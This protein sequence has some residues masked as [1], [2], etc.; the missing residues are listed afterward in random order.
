MVESPPSVCPV[1]GGG[2]GCH[3]VALHQVGISLQRSGG[4]CGVN[5]RSGSWVLCSEGGVA[6]MGVVMVL[7]GCEWWSCAVVMEVVWMCW[8]MLV[9][10]SIESKVQLPILYLHLAPYDG[11][12]VTVWKGGANQVHVDVLWYVEAITVVDSWL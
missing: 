11:V 1:A 8:G 12:H 3:V 9:A 7:R 2:W 4:Q 5:W 6:R 10:L